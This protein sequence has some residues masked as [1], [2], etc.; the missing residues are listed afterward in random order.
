MTDTIS[1]QLS[2]W[3]HRFRA[4]DER[5][6]EECRQAWG[7]VVR[8][9]IARALWRQIA[10]CP[11][12]EMALDTARSMDGAELDSDGFEQLVARVCASLVEVG[13]TLNSQLANRATLRVDA[14]N[15]TAVEG[16]SASPPDSTT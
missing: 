12:D 16:A 5:A 11:L 1:V 8:R 2:D 4:G 15:T 9:S 14:V 7:D 13:A 6:V 10:L 3:A